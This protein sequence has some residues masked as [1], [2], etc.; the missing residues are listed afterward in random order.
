MLPLNDAA[1]VPPDAIYHWWASLAW[2]YFHQS[3]PAA[4]HLTLNSSVISI[5]SINK[6]QKISAENSACVLIKLV[7]SWA[8]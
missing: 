8:K 4:K 1:L 7:R 3:T 6:S 5:F 2:L